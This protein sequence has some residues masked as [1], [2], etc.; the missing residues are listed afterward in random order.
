MKT[1]EKE[2]GELVYVL[3]GWVKRLEQK[4]ETANKTIAGFQSENQRLCE[5]LNRANDRINKI[6]L[7]PLFDSSY[8][9]P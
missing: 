5:E 4:L 3:E 1:K 2:L 9:L 7:A 6:P 8:D